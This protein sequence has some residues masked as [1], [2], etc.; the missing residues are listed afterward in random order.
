LADILKEKNRKVFVFKADKNM[1]MKVQKEF[2]NGEAKVVAK[3]L[4][5]N[6]RNLKILTNMD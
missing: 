4:I 3:D 5:D 1:L 2:V 6:L